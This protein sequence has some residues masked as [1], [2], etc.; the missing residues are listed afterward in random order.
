MWNP[1]TKLLSCMF[2][3][4]AIRFLADF[5]GTYGR[6]VLSRR[7]LDT[8]LDQPVPIESVAREFRQAVETGFIDLNDYRLEPPPWTPPSAAGA[9]SRPLG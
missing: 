8:L 9:R 5:N 3:G 6:G 1:K 2:D 4:R 7:Q